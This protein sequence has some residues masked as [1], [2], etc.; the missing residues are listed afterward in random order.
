MEK[1]IY[2]KGDASQLKSEIEKVKGSLGGLSDGFQKIATD[3]KTDFLD[4]T[5]GRET[6]SVIQDT[7][8]GF[9]NTPISNLSGGVAQAQQNFNRG[10]NISATP[11]MG[12][13]G[14]E[15]VDEIL[16]RF[17]REFIDT[18][19]GASREELDIKR[20]ES[21]RMG[22]KDRD[23]AIQ[24]Q[25]QASRFDTQPTRGQG[26]GAMQQEQGVGQL[27]APGLMAAAGTAMSLKSGS[28]VGLLNAV[29]QLPLV[30]GLLA[31]S[32]L[33][34]WQIMQDAST[35][36]GT[37]KDL[38]ML[39]GELFKRGKG[40]RDRLDGVTS[41][42]IYGMTTEDYARAYTEARK[43]VGFRFTDAAGY[44]DI[45]EAHKYY[46]ISDGALLGGARSQISMTDQVS[47]LDVSDQIRKL[48]D[49]DSQGREKLSTYLDTYTQMAGQQARYMES[50]GSSANYTGLI[51]LGHAIGG[52]FDDIRQGGRFAGIDNALRNPGNEFVKA[53]NFGV[54][55][56]AT[57]GGSVLDIMMAQE[58]GIMQEGFLSGV[59][60][61]E[62]SR[63]Y[64]AGVIGIKE[65]LGV[66]LSQADRLYRQYKKDSTP[67]DLL[68][69]NLSAGNEASSRESLSKMGLRYGTTEEREGTT[70]FVG[71]AA[72]SGAVLR[73]GYQDAVSSISD[74][75]SMVAKNFEKFFS[76]ITEENQTAKQDANKPTRPKGSDF[77]DDWDPA[78]A[79]VYNR[80]FGRTEESI[81]EHVFKQEAEK[82][83]AEAIKALNQIQQDGVSNKDGQASIQTFY[84]NLN[85]ASE[86]LG[87]LANKS[88][89]VKEIEI[90]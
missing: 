65:R 59:L 68:D 38:H 55:S 35:Q 4:K 21:L 43:Q 20:G 80:I 63:G 61:E 29:G 8:R 32:G 30:G 90:G 83:K 74:F 70:D 76:Y 56:R 6:Q 64:Q 44:K 87:N 48:T 24:A 41:P 15:S 25:A 81:N 45:I 82:N 33:T 53:A 10:F 18:Y 84:K 2:F 86:A 26:V 79:A 46:G 71:N 19:K 36:Y 31:A 5:F 9:Q 67:F 37:M 72:E 1:N 77:T 17:T 58:K 60:E 88:N 54:L 49:L 73:E 14:G 89:Q 7:L 16:K 62:T 51:G 69:E 78:A 28:P 52:S 39:D 13:D 12:G 40:Q 85:M 50:I 66:S 42:T 27:Q 34:T 3:Y 47:M 75:S 23:D 22:H 57:G 11:N